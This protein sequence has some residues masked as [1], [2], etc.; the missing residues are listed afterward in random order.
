MRK[1]I[2][3]V[4][5][6]SLIA[7]APAA[8][9]AASKEET[10]GVGTGALIGAVAAGPVG[11]VIGVAIGAKVGDTMYQKNDEI[12]KTERVIERFTFDRE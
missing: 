11:F 1:I 8:N 12:D 4:T 5:A 6:L 9:A 10:I 3:T 2:W 7:A